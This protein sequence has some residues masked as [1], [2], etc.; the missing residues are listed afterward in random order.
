MPEMPAL[1]SLRTNLGYKEVSR[2]TPATTVTPTSCASAST[3]PP[4][5]EPTTGKVVSTPPS[6]LWISEKVAVRPSR[7]Q[8]QGL[9]ATA[10]IGEGEAVARLGGRLVSSDDLARLIAQ[11]DAAGGPYVDTMTVFEDAHLVLP[12]GTT[13]HYANHSCDPT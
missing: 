12:P 10:P 7:I 9:F 4:A 11:A 13:I 2:S 6:E 3:A 8:G 5:T 1:R